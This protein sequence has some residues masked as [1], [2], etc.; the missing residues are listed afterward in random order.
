MKIDLTILK[1]IRKHDGDASDHLNALTEILP[2]NF[3]SEEVFNYEKDSVEEL[4]EY[5]SLVG[6]YF[7]YHDGILNY[8]LTTTS[9]KFDEFK[10]VFL[11]KN[12]KSHFN[13]YV[14]KMKANKLEFGAACHAKK[15]YTI[16]STILNVPIRYDENLYKQF[17]AWTT[18]DIFNTSDS[19]A[20]TFANIIIN[21]LNGKPPKNMVRRIRI[22]KNRERLRSWAAENSID[23]E[24][25]FAKLPRS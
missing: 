24:G 2:D 14:K 22:V 18:E 13:E 12:L 19:Y 1:K 4:I 7:Y 9:N 11:M 17:P 15:F 25:V 8:H 20:F 21:T 3:Y 16:L 23:V 5:M 6:E 10:K